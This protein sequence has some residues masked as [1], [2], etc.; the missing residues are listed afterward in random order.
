M[1]AD[2]LEDSTKADGDYDTKAES[3]GCRG[4]QGAAGDCV[5]NPYKIDEDEMGLLKVK[6]E[7]MFVIG[8][9]SGGGDKNGRSCNAANV[10]PGVLVPVVKC[11][12]VVLVTMAL[13]LPKTLHLTTAM[14]G[15]YLTRTMTR[16]SL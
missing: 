5:D 4:Q 6:V 12:P 8:K 11:E 15:G 14:R 3:S 16:T 13:K 10:I 1:E 7:D 9:P 2:Q